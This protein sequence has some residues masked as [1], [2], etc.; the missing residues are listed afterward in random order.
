MAPI[1]PQGCDIFGDGPAFTT[2][3]KDPQSVPIGLGNDL[4]P[5]MG[6]HA[7]WFDMH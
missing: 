7:P 1:V 3:A 5:K 2:E 6:E 4:L